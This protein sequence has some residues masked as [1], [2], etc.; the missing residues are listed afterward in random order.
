M[1]W[2]LAT[3]GTRDRLLICGDDVYAPVKIQQG[4]VVVVSTLRRQ[5]LRGSLI[6]VNLRLASTTY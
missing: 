2:G 6:S 1:G 3:K 5:K 4:V